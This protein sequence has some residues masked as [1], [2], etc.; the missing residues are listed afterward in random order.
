VAEVV[1]DG[2]RITDWASFHAECQRAFGFPAFYGA[3]MNAWIDC[4]TYLYDGDGMSRLVLQPGEQLH[5]RLRRA[6]ALRRRE[7]EILQALV[8]CT[9]ATNRRYRE[10]GEPP[11]LALELL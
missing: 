8:E 5:I 2:E 7:P 11:A 1:L 3:N 6:D 4:L 10:A 9:E